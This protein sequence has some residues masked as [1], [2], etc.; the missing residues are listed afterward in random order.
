MVV[1]LP[2]KRILLHKSVNSARWEIS[3]EHY[4][5]PTGSSLECVND[6]LW[7]FFGIDPS[8][9]NDNFV[10][11]RRYLQTKDLQDRNII[12]YIMKLKSSIAFRSE[13]S[14]QFKAVQWS[15]LSREI[16]SNSTHI[17]HNPILGYT[18]NSIMVARELHVREVFNK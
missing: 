1:Q 8:N 2:D 14:S 6:I 15:T 16:M 11:I 9:Y 17:K 12:I 18:L 7:N 4:I 13:T 10:E 3:I 5:S